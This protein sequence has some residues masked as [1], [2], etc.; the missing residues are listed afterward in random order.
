MLLMGLFPGYV[1]L[2]ILPAFIHLAQTFA[3]FGVL[4]RTILMFC[5]LGSHLRFVLGARRAQDPE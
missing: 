3:R 5:R 1:A 2:T 4:F